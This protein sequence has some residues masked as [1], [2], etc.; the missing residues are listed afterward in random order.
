MLALQRRQCPII[1]DMFENELPYIDVNNI[2]VTTPCSQV[3]TK[4]IV[5][6]TDSVQSGCMSECYDKWIDSFY[7]DETLKGNVTDAD[8]KDV[9]DDQIQILCHDE[10]MNCKPTNV[11]TDNVGG[12]VGLA[13]E[14]A[15]AFKKQFYEKYEDLYMKNRD[16]G[17]P[18][19]AIY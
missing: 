16:G 15:V 2:M 9:A 18:L 12:H 5:Q 14:C 6:D 13:V 17:C 10:T 7:N 19:M 1:V 4:S 11:P 8:I 3:S